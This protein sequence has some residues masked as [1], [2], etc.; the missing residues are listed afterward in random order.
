VLRQ[1]YHFVL[2]SSTASTVQFKSNAFAR[3]KPETKDCGRTGKSVVFILSIQDEKSLDTVMSEFHGKCIST[4]STPALV[5]LGTGYRMEDI[6]EAV[7]TLPEFKNNIRAPEQADMAALGSHLLYESAGLLLQR[8]LLQPALELLQKV[9]AVERRWGSGPVLVDGEAAAAAT[10]R[11][12]AAAPAAPAVVAAP[13]SSPSLLRGCR[14]RCPPQQARP[15][16]RR[17]AKTG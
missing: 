7:A 6:A 9:A 13:A 3:F 12:A 1:M 16:W 11:R 15:H 17:R 5:E 4:L 8:G 10:A 2:Q 14:C